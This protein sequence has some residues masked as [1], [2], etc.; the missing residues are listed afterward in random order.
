AP[1][2]ILDGFV[3]GP[4]ALEAWTRGLPIQT[5]DRPFLAYI[6]RHSAGRRMSGALLLAPRGSVAP[7]L[8]NLGRD[9]A[10][11]LEDLGR[12]HEAQ[13]F[14]LAGLL[15]AAL[16]ARP[17]GR[18]LKL[19]AEH[20]ARGRGY[21]LALARLYDDDPGRL[22]EIASYLGNLGFAAEARKLYERAIELDP[23]SRRAA[24]NLALVE[25]D[26]GEADQAVARLQDLVT[27]APG[28]P[29]LSYNLGAALLAEQN[30]A[31]AIQQLEAALAADPDL[32]GARLALAD[33]WVKAGRLGEAEKLLRD[34]SFRAP[35]IAET[36]DM[37]GLVEAARGNWAEARE[38][39]ARALQLDPYRSQA[40]FNIGLALHQEGRL[41]AAARAFQAVLS[42]DPEDA[43]AL[44]NL[45]LVHASA[46]QYEQAA[47]FHRRALL[48]LPHFPEAA[49][50]L[51][52]AYRALG[53]RRKA[54]E[55]FALALQLA[56]GL[57]PAREQ[58]D[59]LGID[60]ARVE[61]E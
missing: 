57:L 36:W 15:E 45:G 33:A 42:I 2:E 39:H 14:V 58:L 52:L 4:A 31:A 12:A 3:A 21:Y 34:L 17:E 44:N 24:L 43:G 16:R 48:A 53:D 32:H 1:E 19:F 20:A 35:W 23:G 51:G 8:S 54:V 37:L 41:E 26:L 30:P 47:D 6:T 13:G 38:L 7:L 5:D 27:A 40:H 56:P 11:I 25:L 59:Q 55:A 50:N 61:A 46:G 22:F 28:N 10:A 49:Y 60:D 18:K 29:L 9:E